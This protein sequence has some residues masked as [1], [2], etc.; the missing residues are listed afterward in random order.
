[1]RRESTFTNLIK[2]QNWLDLVFSCF[3]QSALN[4]CPCKIKDT[5]TRQII[6]YVSGQG[7]QASFWRSK[8]GKKK[9]NGEGK[10]WIKG[11]EMII[12]KTAI[13]TGSSRGIGAATAVLF[14]KK[15]FNVVIQGRN[16]EKL[17]GVKE[18][19]EKAGAAGV[20][21]VELELSKTAGKPY[22]FLFLL[23]FNYF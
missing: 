7:R 14:A 5:Q 8:I 21:V 4:K 1:M 23:E 10:F 20:L 13:I 6:A 16:A 15:G 11:Q 22:Y 19:C 12:S 18:E 3:V 17:Q 2:T 9:R